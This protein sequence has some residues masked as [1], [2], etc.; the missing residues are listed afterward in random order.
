MH[1]AALL[2]N[3]G[4]IILHHQ[5]YYH[6]Q[7]SSTTVAGPYVRITGMFCHVPPTLQA[8]F[9]NKHTVTMLALGWE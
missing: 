5:T 3:G 2:L 6:P 4:N 9:P 1:Q 7:V 8:T